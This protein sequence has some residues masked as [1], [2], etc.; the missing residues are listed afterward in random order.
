MI[1]NANNSYRELFDDAYALLV[2]EGKIDPAEVKAITSL[3]QYFT[4]IGDLKEKHDTVVRSILNSGAVGGNDWNNRFAQYA[5]YLMLP[6]NEDYFVINANTRTISIPSVFSANGVGLAGDTWAE[7][8]MFEI[9]RYFDY[10]DLMRTNIY[11]Q[12]TNPDGTEGATLINL[13]DYDDQ[14]IRFGWPLSSAVTATR[15]GNLTFSIRFFMR[16]PNNAEAIIYSLNILPITVRIRKPLRLEVE[17]NYTDEDPYLFMNAIKNGVASS[18]INGFAEYPI[19]FEQSYENDTINLD[20]D[21]QTFTIAAYTKDL[22]VLTYDWQFKP[23]GTAEFIDIN[24]AVKEEY[25]LTIAH[26][27]RETTDQTR[28]IGKIYYIQENEPPMA[29]RPCDEKDFDDNNA[30]KPTVT[31]YESYS[32]C[33]I[34]SIAEGEEKSPIVG[35]YMVSVTNS[36]YGKAQSSTMSDQWILSSPTNIEFTTDLSETSNILEYCETEDIVY[37]STKTYYIK[38][39][40]N[41]YD[42][43]TGDE[44]EEGITYYERNA[45]TLNIAINID[46][47]A[48][49]SCAWYSKHTES[50]PM[51]LIE[52]A[53]ERSYD[54][55]EPGWY[56]VVVTST[57]N[58]ES[59]TQDSNV[60]RVTTPP[61]APTISYQG[62]EAKIVNINFNSIQNDSYPLTVNAEIEQGL[63]S[64]DGLSYTWMHQVK[65][66]DGIYEDAMVGAYGVKEISGDTLMVSYAGDQ[67][68]FVCKVTNSLN[69]A[70]AFSYSDKYNIM[71]A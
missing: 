53:T 12:W 27:Y 34:N 24:D 19:I 62:G 67:E 61:K 33:R 50:G 39:E 5:K 59:I 14:K 65:D 46:K 30:F 51:A 66:S 71:K 11:A 63:L 49:P 69:G 18:G 20:Q 45:K 58:R 35:T 43:F 42:E 9:D 48:E 68:I 57:L 3:E 47:D 7:T 36:V 41:Q 2:A 15:D 28:V 23:E 17:P 70:Q 13:I 52:G 64:S 21:T 25:G 54:V 26:D 56:K 4:Y 60:A 40:N 8:L 10:V 29:Y 1:T 32:Y 16:D 31:Y 44:F 38:N 55:T 6:I 37:D 22:G